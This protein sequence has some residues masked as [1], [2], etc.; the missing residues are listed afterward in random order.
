MRLKI[1]AD[2]SVDEEEVPGKKYIK[3]RWT[4]LRS[5]KQSSANVLREQRMNDVGQHLAENGPGK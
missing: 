4:E 2:M 1:G 5:L 3:T